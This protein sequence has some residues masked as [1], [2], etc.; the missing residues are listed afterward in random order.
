MKSG[1]MY[2]CSTLLI[3]LMGLISVMPAS[4][5]QP[6]SE[7]TIVTSDSALVALAADW[8]RLLDEQKYDESLD[9]AAPLLKR[10]AG[11]VEQWESFLARARPEMTVDMQRTVLDVDHDPDVGPA[12]EGDYVAITFRPSDPAAKVETVTLVETEKGWAPVMYTLRVP[13]SDAR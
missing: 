6:D 8:L 5:Q 9:R 10:M 1:Y 4:G 7:E 2:Y 13:E 3:G 12:P 11:S